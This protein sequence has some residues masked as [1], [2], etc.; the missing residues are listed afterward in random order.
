LLHLIENAAQY[1]PAGT[2]ITV[3]GQVAGKTL[4]LS[5]SDRGPGLDPEELPRLFDR[6]VRGRREQ[7]RP[8]GTGMG[9]AITRGLLAVQN[10]RV[11][12]EN[13]AS[14]GAEFSISIPAESRPVPAEA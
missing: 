5:V 10:G 7:M 14:G 11:W 4:Q 9:L 2:P 3:R 13:L 1:S 6:F 12:A 8:A